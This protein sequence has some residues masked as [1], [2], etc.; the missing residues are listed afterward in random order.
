MAKF[1]LSSE[2]ERLG[3]FHGWPDV[4]KVADVSKNVRPSALSLAKAGFS[5][6]GSG[7]EVLC[8]SCGLR[9]DGWEKHHDPLV[10]HATRSPH[11]Q[12]VS[13][14]EPANQPV[15][16]PP[17][18][19]YIKI[20]AMLT[21][22][23]IR[24]TAVAAAG[25]ASLPQANGGS[26][27]L[28]ADTL[29]MMYGDNMLSSSRQSPQPQASGTSR[30][31]HG[32]SSSS[33]SPSSARGAS[34]NSASSRSPSQNGSRRSSRSGNSASAAVASSRRGAT[35]ASPAPG[36][37]SSPRRS[38]SS[39][40]NPESPSRSSQQGRPGFYRA[41]SYA[42]PQARSSRSTDTVANRQ[43]SLSSN[44]ADHRLFRQSE[45]ARLQT[46]QSWGGVRGASAAQF[47]QAGFIYIGPP[48]R[49]QCV[50]CQGIL[51]NW[52]DNDLPIEEHR[53]HFPDCAF[54][55]EYFSQPSSASARTGPRHSN[56]KTE[57]SRRISFNNWDMTRTPTPTE[58][59]EAGFFYAGTLFL[60]CIIYISALTFKSTFLRKTLG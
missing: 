33:S 19:E 18:K 49:V 23:G 9:A 10:V 26:S 54:V 45:E 36:S 4:V 32:R 22:L 42:Q 56:F 27:S 52:N 3:T 11:C 48:D 6:T 50:M 25:A 17:E 8:F 59:A 57:L 16:V 12:L 41:Q 15:F 34:G 7:D 43:T 46:F 35:N 24:A 21:E 38:S 29:S 13:G 44:A 37:N 47:A 14:A 30:K 51:K 1:N 53:K 5:F 20:K 58:L 2:L 40:V 39:E 28:L 31:Y 60:S 55:K